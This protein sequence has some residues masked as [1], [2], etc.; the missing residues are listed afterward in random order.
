MKVKTIVFVGN[1]NVGKSAWINALADVSL[2][3]GN[4]AGVTVQKHEAV[5]ET[6][7]TCYHLIDLPGCYSLY[8]A[9]Q[10]ER[11]ACEYL[12]EHAVDLIVHVLDA[13]NLSR[14]LLLT[15]ELRELGIPMLLLFNFMDEVKKQGIG[16]DIEHMAK[17]LQ[18]PIVAG[19]AHDKKCY[20][21]V[22]QQLRQV[23]AT[24]VSRNTSDV[25]KAL[26]RHD[27][28]SNRHWQMV[29]E[30]MRDV[31]QDIQKR[32]GFTERIDDVLLHRLWGLPLF[33][34]ILLFVMLLIFHL[35]RPW[36][37]WIAALCDE[38]IAVW[39]QVLL[40]DGSPFWRGL[41]L[42]GILGGVG[43]VLS[44]VPLL[45]CLHI[46]LGILEES[47]YMARIAFLFDRLLRQFH[48]SGS[49]M[50]IFMMGFGCNVPSIYATRVLEEE[51]QRR[52]TA[53]LVPFM[54]CG[55][56]LPVYTL[57]AAA[58]FPQHAVL[59][60]VSLYGIGIVA[61]LFLALLFGSRK[62]KQEEALFVMEMPPYRR[63]HLRHIL[64]KSGREIRSYVRKACG[65]VL[66]AMT[67]L[68]V[69]GYSGNASAADS[70][71]AKGAKASAFLFEPL[72]FGDRWECVAALPGG[73][74]AKET[75]VGYFETLQSKEEAVTVPAVFDWQQ[76]LQDVADMT[77][78]AFIQMLPFWHEADTATDS[79][80]LPRLWQDEHAA[81]KAFSFCCYVLLSI[82][83]VMTLQALYHEYGKRWL[84]VS[85]L[86]MLVVPYVVCLGIYQL[87][88]LL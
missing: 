40:H 21:T 5:M 70:L 16:I 72:G 49:S 31:D 55:A 33:I 8:A 44:F 48:L 83:C 51:E 67:A 60:I 43:G 75:I 84:L 86:L 85:V 69:L 53:L 81:L 82:P 13:T 87:G 46:A 10:E 17:C 20:D 63:V 73:I 61:A 34:L 12:Q 50:L 42:Q 7:D 25:K 37:A 11:I 9:K 29:H 54:S 80:S 58:F 39:L 56:R 6:A 19:S 28:T 64:C 74:L 71:L 2:P 57:F 26:W 38:H 4:W 45:A 79:F 88:A 65:I 52:L 14:N 76:H 77:K 23:C 35:S 66:L 68:W 3:V 32:Y 18:L 22:H 30:L 27:A 62:K 59:C 1:P 78:A 36:T 47:G 41:L 24:S 15:M